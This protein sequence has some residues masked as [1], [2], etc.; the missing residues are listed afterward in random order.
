MDSQKL[1]VILR[2]PCSYY[3]GVLFSGIGL[4]SNLRASNFQTFPGGACPQTPL[5]LHA[6]S[7]HTDTHL[8][9][10][11]KNPG[12]GPGMN[13]IILNF[14]LKALIEIREGVT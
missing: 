6:Y 14:L 12:Y 7:I 2:E 10:P 9:P 8:I 1:N 5:V 4:R 3:S 13:V 11:S